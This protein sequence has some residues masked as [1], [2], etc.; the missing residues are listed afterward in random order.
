MSAMT[1]QARGRRR[2][3]KAPESK[4][5][6]YWLLWSVLLY[7]VIFIWYLYARRTQQYPGPFYDPLRLFGIVAYV[8]VLSTASYSL[9]RR[10]ARNLPGKV[11]NWLWMHTWLGITTIL[12]ALLHENFAR[13]THDYCQNLS[14]LT[15]AHWGAS[16]LFALIFLVV[17]GIVGRLLDM[18]QTRVI[19]R[20]AA[21]NGVGI[22]SAL[23]E[24]I[25]EQE[26][27]VE[28]LSAG[29]SE[30]FKQFCLQALADKAHTRSAG[31]QSLPAIALNE[32]I[33]FQRAHQALAIHARL[34]Q[35]LQRQRFARFIMHTWRTL[36]ITLACIALLVISYHA[37]MELLTNVFHL[38]K[39]V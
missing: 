30:A 26:Y 17:S 31:P 12:I 7:A 20:E 9:R 11:Q 4:A 13:I 19:A 32:Q 24:R 6:W 39:S 2:I 37:I 34:V 10:F 23:E 29:K 18:W 1:K 38:I 22:V 25:L 16:A 36:H 28:R 8:L 3:W 21:T 33:D 27:T 5:R 14:C 15:N 35:S